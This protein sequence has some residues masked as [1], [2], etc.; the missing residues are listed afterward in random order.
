MLP[1]D[2]KGFQPTRSSGRPSALAV[3]SWALYDFANA[4][5]SVSIVSGRYPSCIPRREK[6]SRAVSVEP[7]LRQGVYLSGRLEVLRPLPGGLQFLLMQRG[8]LDYQPHRPRPKSA[9]YHG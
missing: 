8:P 9:S 4:I 3:W 7:R 5:F 6:Y 2:A 1:A